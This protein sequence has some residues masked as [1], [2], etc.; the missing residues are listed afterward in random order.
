MVRARRVQGQIG[1]TFEYIWGINLIGVPLLCDWNLRA[2]LC[3][4]CPGGEVVYTV[5]HYH[6]ELWKYVLL[7][8]VRV[9]ERIKTTHVLYFIL[10]LGNA[11]HM[12]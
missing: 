11:V 6:Q 12:S 1:Y 8:D 4:I 5:R 7:D 2:N 3:K 10:Q 9:A